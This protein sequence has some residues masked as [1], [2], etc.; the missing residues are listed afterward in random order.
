MISSDSSD[1]TL[2]YLSP[3]LDRSRAAYESKRSSMDN[4]CVVLIT[5]AGIFVGLIRDQ[6]AVLVTVAACLGLSA[7][8]IGVW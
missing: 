6:S 5:G 7:A 3:E 1:E 8:M 2:R 4:K